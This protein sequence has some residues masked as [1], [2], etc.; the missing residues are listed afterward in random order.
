MKHIPQWNGSVINSLRPGDTYSSVKLVI[1]PSDNC[2]LPFQWQAITRSNYD[3]SGSLEQMSLR[4]ELSGN[5]CHWRKCLSKLLF[6]KCWLFSLQWHHIV[7]MVS[8]IIGN[9]AVYST[10]YSGEQQPRKHQSSSPLAICVGN[11][12]VTLRFPS[13]RATN[14]ERVSM[15]WRIMWSSLN[16]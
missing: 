3:Q 9:S 1:M 5:N 7:I 2:V 13:Q 8:Q 10:A 12:S 15:S 6:A 4:F 16:M 11:P 14:A